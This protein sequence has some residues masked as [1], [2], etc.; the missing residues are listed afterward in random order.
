MN[1][2]TNRA[3]KKKTHNMQWPRQ[4]DDEG[5]LARSAKVR[6]GQH[7]GETF[8][9]TKKCMNNHKKLQGL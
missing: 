5:K 7:D 3:K 1:C 6:S 9:G 8:F 2:L 4:H